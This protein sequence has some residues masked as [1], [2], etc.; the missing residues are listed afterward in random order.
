MN[1][2]KHP[3]EI[4]YDNDG[5]DDDDMDTLAHPLRDPNPNRAA[6]GAAAYRKVL[7]NQLHLSQNV[8]PHAGYRLWIEDEI[9]ATRV[10]L[11]ALNSL[12]KAL[13]GQSPHQ[14]PPPGGLDPAR[15]RSALQA[16]EPITNHPRNLDV[17]ARACRQWLEGLE[18][19]LPAD[20]TR[21]GVTKYLDWP[22]CMLENGEGL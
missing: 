10:T 16:L 15:A 2:T 12:E 5:W 21:D 9:T 3:T 1:H 6:Q 11:W 22:V 4:A 17:R 8:Q 13:S 18:Q 20:L 7:E 14:T 19:A